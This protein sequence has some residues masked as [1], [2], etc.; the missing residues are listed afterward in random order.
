[1]PLPAE[2]SFTE[3][4][5]LR[6]HAMGLANQAH[7]RRISF[8]EN[9][10]ADGDMHLLNTANAIYEFLKIGQETNETAERWERTD[11]EHCGLDHV[12]GGD[13]YCERIVV[14]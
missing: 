7:E 3:D 4:T 9:E 6:L 13:E 12:H 14:E 8:K 11:A 2:E 10:Q 5:M 1:M